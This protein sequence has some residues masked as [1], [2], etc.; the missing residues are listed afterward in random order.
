MPRTP[1]AGR[2]SP[3]PRTGA[4]AAFERGSRLRPDRARDA[5]ADGMDNSCSGKTGN[6]V[7]RI[8]NMINLT[9][10]DAFRQ[11]LA[12]EDI[13]TGNSVRASETMR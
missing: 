11:M 2:L 13:L 8:L 10:S 1:L 9:V 5:V 12:A 3:D 7:A 6:E 4:R